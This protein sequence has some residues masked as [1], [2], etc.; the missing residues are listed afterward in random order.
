[1]PGLHTTEDV[2]NAK[3]EAE[4]VVNDL[5]ELNTIA[6]EYL[7]WFSDELQDDTNDLDD[8]MNIVSAHWGSDTFLADVT[9]LI[10]LVSLSVSAMPKKASHRIKLAQSVY[11]GEYLHQYLKYKHEQA[12]N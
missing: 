9:M 7:K 11:V 10:H 2:E 6:K 5:A 12:N 1:M 8:V 3:Q 4:K